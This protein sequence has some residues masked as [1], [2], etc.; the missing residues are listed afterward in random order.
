S[1]ISANHMNYTLV[2]SKDFKLVLAPN[3]IN[4]LSFGLS[5]RYLD[6]GFSVTPGFLNPTSTTDKK[7]ESEQFSFGTSFQLHRF[8]LSMDLSSVKG[9]YLKN[10][11]EF[12]RS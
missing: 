4:S 9:F 7:G 8:N 1:R 10:S 5:Y 2:Y 6:L 11:T 3:K 12:L